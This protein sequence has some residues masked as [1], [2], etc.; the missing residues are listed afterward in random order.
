MSTARTPN[1][2]PVL[3]PTSR[4]LYR[5]I[6]PGTGRSF[7]LHQGSLGL[8]LMHLALWFNDVIERLA[9]AS[10][11][12]VDEAGYAYRPQRGTEDKWSEHVGYAV[13][14]NWN[15]HPRGVP[16][17]RTFTRK[18]INAIHARLRW[19]N[20]LAGTQV[21]IWG[22]DWPSHPGS[23]AMPDPMHFELH[24]PSKRC[25]RLAK[26]LARTPRGRKILAANPSQRA[27]IFG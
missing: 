7:T 14:L 6:L 18:Q 3:E 19:F 2:W 26:I 1:G 8:I 23:T 9:P 16:A 4:E 13:D 11:E 24:P 27:V 22:G 10:R 21:I 5:W 25:V 17:V 12:P 15:Q 20:R